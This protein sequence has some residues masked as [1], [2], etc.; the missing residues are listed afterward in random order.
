M[1]IPVLVCITRA[2]V[3]LE[4]IGEDNP[5]FEPEEVVQRFHADMTARRAE[6]L[7]NVRLGLKDDTTTKLI[8]LEKIVPCCFRNLKW[9]STE[10]TALF[11]KCGVKS[12]ED[13]KT[14]CLSQEIMR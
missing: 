5:D 2:D 9:K 8:E 10:Q 7:Q 4:N 12:I 1:D 14:W 6:L 11:Q 13:V 3:I